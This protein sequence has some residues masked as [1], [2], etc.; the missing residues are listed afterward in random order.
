MPLRQAVK[1]R[2]GNGRRGLDHSL[3][4]KDDAAARSDI[5]VITIITITFK[6]RKMTTNLENFPARGLYPLTAPREVSI[7][8]HM[9]FSFAKNKIN[10]NH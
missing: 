1:E 5:I 7:S 8:D 9:G 4:N 6:I 2:G 3:K 10:P